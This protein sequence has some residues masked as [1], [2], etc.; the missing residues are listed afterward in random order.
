MRKGVLENSFLTADNAQYIARKF[1]QYKGGSSEVS[2]EWRLF[3]EQLN[4]DENAIL[5]DLA[6]G[7]KYEQASQ[8]VAS[9]VKNK[10]LDSDARDTE[11]SLK[12]AALANAYRRWGHYSA[13]LDPL[14]LLKIKKHPELSLSNRQIKEGDLDYPLKG[15]KIGRRN[16]LRGIIDQLSMVYCGNAAY[17]YMHIP[18]SD[19][20]S[21]IQRR[22][23]TA[24]FALTHEDDVEIFEW[25]VK[26][27]LFETFLSKK[28]PG[29]KRFGLEGCDALIPV[30]H[31]LLTRAATDDLEKS[32]I[33]MAHRG[34]LNTLYNIIGR[35]LE[36]LFAQFMGKYPDVSGMGDVKYHMG[37]Q[38][39]VTLH[40]K[41]LCVSLLYNP[42]HLEAVNP[43]VMGNVWAHQQLSAPNALGILVHGDAAFAGQGVNAETLLMSQV[44]GYSVGGMIHIITNNQIGFT[45]SP[46][47]SRSTDY[48][49][50]LAK[51]VNAPVFHANAD[52]ISACIFV[53]WLA[54]SY[55]KEFKKDV[56]IDLV[57]YRRNGHNEGDEP[58]FTQPAMYSQIRSHA[59]VLAQYEALLI[60][61]GVVSPEQAMT[62][63]GEYF[64]TLTRAFNAADTWKFPA[65]KTNKEPPSISRGISKKYFKRVA[66][67][68]STPPEG[69]NLNPKIERLLKAREKMFESGE[70]ID[71]ATGELLA[72]GSLLTEG[73]PVRIS[74]EDSIRGTFSHRHIGVCDQTTSKQVFP[75][76]EMLDADV[77]VQVYNSILSEYGVMGFEYGVALG[78]SDRL[79][80]WEAQ[81]GDFSNG[82]QIMI[83]QF[84]AS[85]ETKWG[86]QNGIV[87]LLPH[88]MEGQGPE[89]SSARLERFL[90]LCAENNMCVATPTTP[91]SMF[92]LL[93]RQAL[94]SYKRPL[95]IMTPK[96]LLR[97]K[98]AVSLLTE[99]E[100]ASSFKAVI[101]D[102]VV[103]KGS[104]RVV[105]CCGK[106]Y[107]DL[108]ETQ[109]DDVAIIRI[110]E[111]YPF[112]QQ[113]L[114]AVLK[115]HP[116]AE[117]IWCQEEPKN[118]GAWMH[119]YFQLQEMGVTSAYIG[120]SAAS[121]PATG[122]SS[123]HSSEQSAIIQ[124]ALTIKKV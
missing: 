50:D 36:E 19:E 104:R 83:D 2:K 106:I 85:A 43:V 113:E 95:I 34:R 121:S 13:T 55:R 78:D 4:D 8:S 98:Y 7:S 10:T 11:L 122:Y 56:V 99:F 12:A 16:T 45:A 92:H 38:T 69:F 31:D 32:V 5:L 120:R 66:D 29:A 42:S 64:E 18:N 21:W 6:R 90:Q 61:K 63:R 27:E 91:A 54:Y 65:Q 115:K 9:L 109:P 15:F 68:I 108:L 110:E 111:L 97:H 51:S 28:F 47:E 30:L 96:S 39:D 3:F 84:I 100:E 103:T 87:L 41:P 88:G 89:H 105:L 119:V 52:D 23:E 67:A 123:V 118:M 49:S 107:Y 86:Q 124:A 93:R 58:K 24:P 26:S 25:L 94:S 80:I 40:D 60:E 57:G 20:V 112:P 101:D 33:G 117:V 114:A 1:Q 22:L 73:I 44:E 53:S 59:S 102:K 46:S 77:K 71:W 74:G 82:A 35:P 81:F 17:E 62:I 48:A 14:G 116:K 76:N 72:Y 37:G 75:L 79:V 70:N